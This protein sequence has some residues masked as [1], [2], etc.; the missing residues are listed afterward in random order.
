M[1]AHIVLPAHSSLLIPCP[2][3]K[4]LL[5]AA[6]R[7]F[8]KPFL[9]FLFPPSPSEIRV[10]LFFFRVPDV[11]ACTLCPYTEFIFLLRSKVGL[12]K[13]KFS[14]AQEP[15]LKHPVG[16]GGP[17]HHIVSVCLSFSHLP[18]SPHN[19]RRVRTISCSP[20]YPKCLTRSLAHSRCSIKACGI[21]NSSPIS[22][23]PFTS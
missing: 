18:T 9:I 6:C 16:T 13:L 23:T 14:Q 19:R 10:N 8:R 1:C 15:C 4:T 12:C 17:P 22:L 11:L 20:L 7:A 3:F 21:K 5:I 2:S